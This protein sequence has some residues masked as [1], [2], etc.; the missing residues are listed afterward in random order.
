MT[1]CRNNFCKAKAE[2][3]HIIYLKDPEVGKPADA[4][5]A[6]KEEEKKA[7]QEYIKD[8]QNPAA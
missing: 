4:T 8:D 6:P 5:T 3:K 2:E 7:Q 1:Y